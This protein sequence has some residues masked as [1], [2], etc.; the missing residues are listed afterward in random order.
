ME[1]GEPCG[2]QI[3]WRQRLQRAGPRG[4][5]DNIKVLKRARSHRG[6]RTSKLVQQEEEASEQQEAVRAAGGGSERDTPQRREF[7][8]K[9]LSWRLQDVS[10]VC[11]RQLTEEDYG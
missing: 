5:A 8:T 10:A 7:I 1:A 2:K 9:L 11:W 4:E 3:I 6:W